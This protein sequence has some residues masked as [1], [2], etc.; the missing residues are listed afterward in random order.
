MS[1][2]AS[3]IYDLIDRAYESDDVDEIAAL[4]ERV[5]ELAPDNPEALLLK[6]ELIED[7]EERLLLL[8]RA[9][10]KIKKYFEEQG[11]S[12]EA[13]SEDDNS[14]VYFAILKRAAYVRFLLED[15]DGA[16]ELIEE[17]LPFDPYDQMF[18]RS[19][20]YRILLE[21]EEWAAVLEDTM[22]QTEHGLGWAYS[23]II[24]TYML[25]VQGK[26]GKGNKKS[27]IAK[28]DKMLWPA[29]A[30]SPDV[31]FYMLGYFPDPVDD[32]EEEEDAFEFGLL[33]EGIWAV[34]RDMLNWFSKS[35][36]LFG[37]LSGRF[38]DEQDDMA[39]ILDAL[40]GGDDYKE[41]FDKLGGAEPDEVVLSA[42]LS[43]GYPKAR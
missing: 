34:S 6:S 23:R 13:I 27:D 25:S 43:G 10:A 3:D 17:L 9:L 7:D 28:I 11:L 30:M 26:S 8:E 21:R 35:V 16:M 22:K 14:E 31:P 40:G 33:F 42:I 12:G 24:A 5:L 1:D 4:T 29:I 15:D 19:F 18:S 39:E 2:D 36:I 38:G 41:L 20:Y 37:L 32:T